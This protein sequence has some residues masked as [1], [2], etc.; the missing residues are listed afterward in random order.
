MAAYN[1]YYPTTYQ[2]LYPQQTM[3]T[4][5]QQA[6]P[7]QTVMPSY[8]Q[9]QMPQS[10]SITWVQ[11]EAGAKAHPLAP[12]SNA[13]LMDSESEVFYI[14][15]VDGSGMPMPLRTFEYKE[16][17]PAADTVG[18]RH[19][20]DTEQM[21][22]SEYAKQKDIDEIKKIVK[23]MSDELKKLNQHREVKTNGKQTV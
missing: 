15:S 18:T 20:H 11:G 3:Q 2:P 1:T 16:I 13:L 6:Q 21:D 12:G 4:M 23:D 10:T 19:S 8:Q 14:K 9:A 7:A 17:F 5:Y 22:M